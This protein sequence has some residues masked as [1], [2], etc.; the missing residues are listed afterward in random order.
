MLA[1]NGIDKP[2][3]NKNMAKKKKAMTKDEHNKE[4]QRLLGLS[5][6]MHSLPTAWYFDWNGDEPPRIF[7]ANGRCVCVLSTGTFSGAYETEQI[8]ANAKR[9]LSGNDV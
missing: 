2:S 7:D 6:V 5:N 9:L 1:A 3:N 4:A 8:I